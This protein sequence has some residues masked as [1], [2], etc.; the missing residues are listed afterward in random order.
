MSIVILGAGRVGFNLAR[1]LISEKKEVVVIEKDADRARDL[2]RQLDCMTVNESGNS[3]EGL[4]KAGVGNAEFFISL[5]ESDEINMISCALVSSSFKKPVTIAR[6]RNLDYSRT[7]DQSPGFLGINYI[8]NPEIEAAHA[9]AR[10]VEFGAIST[11]VEF[12]TSNLQMRNFQVKKHSV[13][14][15]KRI[16]ELRKILKVPFIIAAI[17]R[18]E[19]MIIPT[20]S[21]VL[22]TGDQIWILAD[23]KDFNTLLT[24]VDAHK[25]TLKDI[26]IV[27][28]GNIGMYIAK[29][30][31]ENRTSRHWLMHNISRRP[32]R[33]S[34]RNIHIIESDY[35]RCKELSELL[36]DV[37]I[38]NADISEERIIEEGRF[39]SYDLLI[40]ATG[41]PELNIITAAYAGKAGIP[42]SIALVKKYSTAALAL[43]LGVSV[44]VSINE[45]LVNSIQKIIRRKFVRSVYQFSDSDLEILELS[46]ESRPELPGKKIR[47][48]RLP[49]KPLI[50]MVSRDGKHIIPDGDLVLEEH[51]YLMII[52]KKEAVRELE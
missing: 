23:S 36:P 37:Q 13:L 18:D 6:V 28:G 14:F 48:I 19:T 30:L 41:N 10:A 50:L 40:S 2:S 42:H 26:V 52:M 15:G 27:G 20:G 34:K 11:V 51:D 17:A 5:S 47:D 4:T 1:Q 3:I 7:W 49:G 39:Q 9:V 38:T 35:Q 44:A 12:E 33:S 45:S 46:L 31:L 22:E 16:E 8:V 25:R 21:T 43:N 24:A 32:F 29:Y